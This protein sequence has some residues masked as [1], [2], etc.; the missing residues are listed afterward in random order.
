MYAAHSRCVL[1]VDVWDGEE[2][3]TKPQEYEETEGSEHV[4]ENVV[5]QHDLRLVNEDIR[6]IVCSGCSVPVTSN[7]FYRCRQCNSLFHEQCAIHPQMKT[8]FLHVHPL[9]LCADDERSGPNALSRC[10]ACD[11]HISGIRYRCESDHIE[12]D[13]RCSSVAEPFHYHLHPEHLFFFPLPAEEAKICNVCKQ[14]GT[15][16]VLS[17]STCDFNLCF[18]CATL[19]DKVIYK[20][21]EHL[22][23]HTIGEDDTTN[24]YWCDICENEIEVMKNHYT[25]T[26]CGPVLHTECVLGSFRNMSPGFTFVTQ[27]GHKYEVILN[28]RTSLLRCSQCHKDCHEPLLLMSTTTSTDVTSTRI[29]L[30]SS[31]CFRAYVSV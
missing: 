12:F 19:P 24:P 18:A 16:Y 11:L 5:H 20:Y 21:D 27:H 28:D 14:G 10:D 4:G 31:P 7:P 1:R 23:L 2:L 6:D 3:E 26:E 9:T 8:T 13:V 17:C 22:L 29:Y 30:C 15:K 25:C